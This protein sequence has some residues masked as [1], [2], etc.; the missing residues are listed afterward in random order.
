R[1]PVVVRH[2]HR[3]DAAAAGQREDELAAAVRRR[4]LPFEL[5]DLGGGPLGECLTEFLGQ[6]AHRL[7][8]ED[9]FAIEPR[10]ELAA[11]ITRGAKLDGEILELRGQK[12]DEIQA[13]HGSWRISRRLSTDVVAESW[14][15]VC[16]TGWRERL[17]SGLDQF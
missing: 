16:V 15:T 1:D 2:Q 17:F 14:I 3:A 4:R 12:A 8:V 13:R 10:R 7:D 5:R 6:I 11:S 9:R